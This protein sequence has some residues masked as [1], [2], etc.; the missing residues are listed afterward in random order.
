MDVK[1]GSKMF[2]S[3][4]DTQKKEMLAALN[5]KNISDLIN[6][7]APG[8]P[9]VK[10]SL[11]PAM[12]E[13]ELSAHVKTL[14]AKNKKV[15]NF[16]GAGAYEHFIPA[17]VN[18]ISSRGEFLT[19][20]TPYQAEASQGTLQAIYEYQSCVCAL[21][22][23]DISNASHYDGAT[24][25]AEAVI[26]AVKIK[27]KNTVLIP[28]ALHPHY[29]ETLNTY[30]KYAGVKFEEISC[31]SGGMDI[32]DLKNKLKGDAAAVVLANPNFY[33][34]IEDVDA[35]S[36]AVKEAGALLI[37][38]VNPLS[39]GALRTPGSYGADFAVG[40]GQPLGNALNFGGPYLGIFTCK[41]EFV[42]SL[43]GRV[44]G[45]AKDKDGGRAYVLTLQ[46]REQHI[47]R[48]R[49]ASNICSNQALCAL[50]AA[51]YLTLLGPKGLEEVC[52]LNLENADYLKEKISKLKGFK[53]K[54][55]REFFNEFVIECPKP[56]AE[57]IKNMTAK[58]IAAGFDLGGKDLLVCATETK[59]KTEI[60]AF[61]AAL[62]GN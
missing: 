45:I 5:C 53:I 4:S 23:M 38:A 27:N 31:A 15:L 47:R 57:I 24:A 34:V 39:L 51:V 14:A 62:G 3:N 28:A 35:I 33:G 48:E 58:N 32:A 9:P 6:S 30:Y 13:V 52:A 20:Y 10:F 19:A 49:S 11:P 59:T 1:K 60:D 36:A 44:V 26:A 12:T 7:A 8:L 43:P 37:A 40:E 55:G 54:Y 22:D 50:N 2:I 21:F 18:S 42:R 29:K 56:A 61:A 17:A 25:L 41:K 46:A 16:C